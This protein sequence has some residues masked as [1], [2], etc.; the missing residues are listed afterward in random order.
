[1]RER[2]TSGK[3]LEL[4]HIKVELSEEDESV[5]GT[6]ERVDLCDLVLAQLEEFEH[7][8]VGD[9]LYLGQFIE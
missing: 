7:L 6:L 8:Q 9:A 5:V 4:V 2:G 1:M 3:L